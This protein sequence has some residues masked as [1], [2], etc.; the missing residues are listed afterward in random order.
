MIKIYREASK[1]ARKRKLEMRYML[2]CVLL[3]L[4]SRFPL[5]AYLFT[6]L[7]KCNTHHT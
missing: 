4:K 5:T 3:A 2:G 1:V 7:W 6:M